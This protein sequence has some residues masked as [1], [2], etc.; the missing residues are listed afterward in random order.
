MNSGVARSCADGIGGVQ[1]RLGCATRQVTRPLLRLSSEI[2]AVYKPYFKRERGCA[3]HSL[4]PPV[5]QQR[6]DYHSDQEK[7]R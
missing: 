1:R 4:C 3:Y 5:G 6:L 2:P 7:K